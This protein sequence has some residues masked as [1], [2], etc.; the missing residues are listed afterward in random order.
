MT[1]KRGRPSKFSPEV[2]EK[3]VQF[4]RA[5]CYM[6]TAAEA[7]GITRE[8]LYDWLG[9]GARGR[10][11][12]AQFQ[13]DVLKASAEAEAVAVM[14]LTKAAKD[15]DARWAAWMLERRFPRKYGP[16]VQISVQEELQD[17]I[18]RLKVE[19]AASPEL[20]ERALEAIAGSG[21]GGAAE[22]P[23]YAHQ[24]AD[25]AAG[26]DPPDDPALLGAAAPEG[27]D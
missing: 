21:R 13:T 6:Q 18:E 9:K 11:P 10:E 5:G 25:P 7:S 26:V 23:L 14:Q 1:R 3:I 2:A 8:T 16:R 17:A 20:L 15:G 4:L 12:F 27:A 22:A 19:F 24:A